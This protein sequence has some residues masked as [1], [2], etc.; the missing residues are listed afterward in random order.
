VD[1]DPLAY[2]C[3]LLTCSF[4]YLNK[5]IAIHMCSAE[6]KLVLHCKNVVLMKSFEIVCPNT[7]FNRV[8]QYVHMHT[9]GMHAFFNFTCLLISFTRYLFQSIISVL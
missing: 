5:K 1:F 6:L 2:E 8:W 9:G 7:F 3:L 4:C